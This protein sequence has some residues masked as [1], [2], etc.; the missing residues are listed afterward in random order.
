[1]KELKEAVEKLVSE[2]LERANKK[3]PMFHSQHEGYAVIKEEIE[4]LKDNVDYAELYLKMAWSY[5]K[6][7]DIKA[8][9]N[10]IEDIQKNALLAAAEAI[11][12]A[13]MAQKYKDSF[14]VK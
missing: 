6:T 14:K 13:A 11:Q 7:N 5:I 2:E 12:V 4:E 3:F 9:M 1:M 8:A 10:F